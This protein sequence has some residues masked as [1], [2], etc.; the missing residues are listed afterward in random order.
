MNDAKQGAGT[1][2]AEEGT[3]TRAVR[4]TIALSVALFFVQAT[5]LA[6]GDVASAFGFSA[7]NAGNH[8]WAVATFTVVHENGWPLIA[9][10]LVLG[11]FGSYLERAWGT[12]EFV[13]YYLVC[14]LGAWIAHVTFVSPEIV[15]TG[16][17]APATGTLL[18]FAAMNGGERHFRVGAVSL[19]TGSLA[20]IGTI[21]V[22]VAGVATSDPAVAAAYLVHGAGIV[23]GWAYMRT[24]SSINL[25]R[26]RDGVSPVPDEPEDAPPRAVPRNHSRVQRHDDDIVARSNAATAREATAR[27]TPPPP[28]RDKRITVNEVLDKISR[29]GMESLTSDERRLLDDTSRRLRD[30]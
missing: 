23:A 8:W 14:S 27:V 24:A 19:S 26:I 3:S 15:L 17:A 18:A 20:S 11:V 28:E 2:S 10:L 13:R 9:N 1:T 7:N 12:G 6:P 25:G 21:A 29:H 4:A 30:R 5:V 22:L 16:A